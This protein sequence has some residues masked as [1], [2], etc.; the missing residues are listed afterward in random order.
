[1]AECRPR[2]LA[3]RAVSLD[4]VVIGSI[5]HDLTL[6]TARHPAPGETV[7]GSGHYTGGGGKGA[8]Q[9]VA[10]ARL[11][12]R[13]AMVGRVGDDETGRALVRGLAAEDIDVSAISVDEEVPTGL[14]VI[15]VDDRAENTIVVSPGA[16]MGL[17]PAHL[18]EDMVVNARV[19]LAQL[20]VPIETVT[21]AARLATGRFILNPAPG[22]PLPDD[23][24]DSVHVL[25]P[26]RSE[27]GVLAGTDE[28]RTIVEVEDAAR[29]IDLDAAV[30]VTLGAE[31]AL[32]VTTDQAKLIPAPDV[33][34][35]DPTG[36]GDAF[37]AAVAHGLSAGMDLADAVGMAV[38]AGALATTRPGAQAAM[39]TAE[40]VRAHLAQ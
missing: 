17:L 5:N 19:V 1:M 31:G 22:R 29:S 21:A 6:M 33:S 11:G 28:P 18:D 26:N 4:I 9:A 27:L 24:M 38:I 32:L 2:R 7:L 12:A 34:A 3:S 40:E 8:N 14:A 37:C 30:V 25:V 20:E 36:A 16:N 10:A 13:V 39:P 15:T 23:L 35:V